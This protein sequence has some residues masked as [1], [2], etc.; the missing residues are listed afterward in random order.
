MSRRI[1]VK[2][3]AATGRGR[4]KRKGGSLPLFQC[5]YLFFFF[6]IVFFFATFFFFFFAGIRTSFCAIIIII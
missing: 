2:S 3:S 1:D 4:K 6:F 5:Y